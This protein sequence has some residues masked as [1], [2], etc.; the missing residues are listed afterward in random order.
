MPVTP[1]AAVPALAGLFGGYLAAFVLTDPPG[2]R[3]AVHTSGRELDRWLSAQPTAI[4]VAVVVA[5]ATCAALARNG[6]R[7]IGWAVAAACV[8]VLLGVRLAVPGVAGVDGLIALH[9]VKCLAAGALLGA[10]VA[11]GW[12]H[13]GAQRAV[14]AGGLAGFL[15]V[16]AWGAAAARESTSTLGEPA[17]WLIGVTLALAAAAAATANVSSRIPRITGPEA[18]AAL[19]TVVVL[20]AVNRLQIAWIGQGGND[21]RL[22]QWVVIAVAMVVVLVATEVCARLIARRTR[23]GDG[24]IV[25]A[26]TGVAAA[27]MPVLVDLRNPF[28]DVP[29]AAVVAVAAVAVAVGVA[30]AVRRPAPIAGLAVAAAVPVV[31][32]IWPDLGAQG[33]LLLVRLAVVGVGAGWALASALPGSAAV[34]A[35]GL[36]IPFA[37]TV[38]HAAATVIVP[39]SPNVIFDGAYEPLRGV[40]MSRAYSEDLDAFFAISSY[41]DRMAGIALAVAVAFCAWGVRGVRA[42]R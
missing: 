8:A 9:T 21:T 34:A 30:V 41:D 15:S 13:R 38:F 10:A 42:V 31:G 28:R 16:S 12:G 23:S 36:A 25:L 18:G 24:A 3:W 35:V 37:S 26:A 7:R 6:S 11:A 39:H 1:R 29:S 40:E 17:W 4:A 22:R 5:A 20:A 33:P 27:A 19:L 32:A 2:G 14:A